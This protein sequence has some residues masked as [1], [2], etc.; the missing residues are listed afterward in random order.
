MMTVRPYLAF[1]T[2]VAIHSIATSGAEALLPFYM[3][4]LGAS[5]ALAG[6]PF[7]MNSLSRFFTDPLAG[8]ASDRLGSKWFLL[9]AC[10]LGAL[11]SLL[12]GATSQLAI[13]L[14]LWAFVGASESMFALSIRKIAF[15]NA[16]PGRE[17]RAV[18]N[19]TT[20]YGIGNVVGPPIAGSLGSRLG[21]QVLFL[22]YGAPLLLCAALSWLY[23][24]GGSQP[25]P[26]QQAERRSFFREGRDLFKSRLFWVACL[27]MFFMFFAR[28]GG[29][30]VAFPLFAVEERGLSIADVGS[31]LGVAGGLDM[32]GRYLA[33]RCSDRWG[34]RNAVAWGLFASALGFTA[35]IFMSGYAGLL[36]AACGMALAFGF[37]NVSSTT[38]ALEAAGNNQG[39]LALGLARWFGSMGS[40]TGPFLI[41]L[42]AETL[43]Y[44]IVFPLVGLLAIGLVAYVRVLLRS[45]LAVSGTVG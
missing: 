3:K 35:I 34:A 2:V 30:K 10:L 18:G 17:G 44:G 11:F 4:F 16:P 1:L 24:P 28:W 31:I 23:P 5:T 38:V 22:M 15:E 41:A 12:A 40:T 42:L 7:A 6:L 19:V 9:L 20:L 39:G 36:T 27:A 21:T 37:L 13:F 43:G 25:K 8:A 29:L 32:L 26:I 33:G 14:A 45:L